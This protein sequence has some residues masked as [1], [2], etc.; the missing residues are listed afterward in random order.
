MGSRRI[1]FDNQL[2]VIKYL[3]YTREKDKHNYQKGND[4]LDELPVLLREK[5]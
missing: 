4:I 3:E 1:S 5:V 2:E